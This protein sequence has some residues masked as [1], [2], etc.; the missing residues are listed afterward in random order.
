MMKSNCFV[1][2][3]YDDM[4]GWSD[5]IE[6]L[7]AFWYNLV[8][9]F[10]IT[11]INYSTNE[12]EKYVLA[13]HAAV[14]LIN[15]LISFA[16]VLNLHTTTIEG[17][18]VYFLRYIEWTICTPLMTCEMC[19]SAQMLAYD[20]TVIVILTLAFTFCGS[21]AALTKY[22]WAKSVLGL[23][24]TIYAMIVVYKLLKHGL[25]PYENPSNTIVDSHVEYE[26]RIN[27][28]NMMASAFI[29][30]MYVIM[31]SLGPDM[32]NLIS[33]KTEWIIENL[34][35]IVLKTVC[36]SYALL[37]YNYTDVEDT[38]ARVVDVLEMVLFT[39]RT[40]N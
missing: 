4:L 5:A 2:L 12:R 27:K 36:A 30:P 17:R 26:R 20:T 23:Q 19:Q 22:F 3:V 31:W 7:V 10:I 1:R 29:W 34:L 14:C 15:S 35:S 39:T 25:S 21:I 24:G 6:I 38:M 28:L 18:T 40:Q 16:G 8:G 11:R 33:G 37:T 32:F 13:Y 9:V